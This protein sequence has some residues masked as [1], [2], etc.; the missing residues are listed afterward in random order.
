[1]HNLAHSQ[2]ISEQTIAQTNAQATVQTFIK[3]V[4]SGYENPEGFAGKVKIVVPEYPEQGFIAHMTDTLH[5][6]ADNHQQDTDTCITIPLATM[7]R[8]CQES[9]YLDFRDPEIIGTITLAG[10]LDYANHLGKACLQP[11]PF[12]KQ[13]LAQ[14]DQIHRAHNLRQL[15]RLDTLHQ[16]SQMQLLQQLDSNQP[17]IITGLA[18]D[19]Q[20]WSLERLVEKFGDSIVRVRSAQQSQTMAEFVQEL[21]DF[22]ANPYDHMIE[23]FVKPYTEGAPCP[24][25]CGMILAPCFLTVRTLFR[26]S[27]G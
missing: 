5:I 14:A 15:T 16:P 25:P 13:R 26:P 27:Y 3:L 20:H 23:G 2:A 4:Q 18:P 17:F 24:K 12:V 21:K 6:T 9:A 10:N 19:C 8:I 7:E 1:M 22:Q 11:N